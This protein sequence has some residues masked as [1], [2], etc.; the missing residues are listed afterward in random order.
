MKLADHIYRISCTPGLSLLVYVTHTCHHTF[1]RT[2]RI[3]DSVGFIHGITEPTDLTNY[4]SLSISLSLSLSFPCMHHLSSFSLSLTT[5]HL[6]NA[7]ARFTSVEFCTVTR[8]Y[9]SLRPTPRTKLAV[10]ANQLKIGEYKH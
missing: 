2:N 5:M 3:T 10:S 9:F 6:S 1:S 8:T 7:R 4:P